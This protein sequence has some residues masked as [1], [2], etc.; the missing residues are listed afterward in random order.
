MKGLNT[1][2]NEKIAN[3][4]MDDNNFKKKMAEYKRSDTKLDFWHWM[5]EEG[6]KW[7]GTVLY[8]RSKEAL[9]NWYIGEHLWE[10]EFGEQPKEPITYRLFPRINRKMGRHL[11]PNPL[12]CFVNV[13]EIHVNAGYG[14]PEEGGWYYNQGYFSKCFI[15]LSILATLRLISWEKAQKL[16][17]RSRWWKKRYAADKRLGEKHY[18]ATDYGERRQVIAFIQ[19]H[20]GQDYPTHKPYYC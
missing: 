19:E 5:E 10:C 2:V 20:P 8:Q 9:H 7:I 3:Y 14:G 16:V 11:D 1:S 15:S 17:K 18:V 6:S 13:Y 4:L 12:I